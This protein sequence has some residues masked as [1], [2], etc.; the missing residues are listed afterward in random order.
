MAKKVMSSGRSTLSLKFF[1]KDHKPELPF[2]TVV[3]ENGTWQKV[4]SKFLQQ[5]LEFVLLE[6]SL[7]LKNTNELIGILDVHHGKQCSVF[8]MDIKDLYYSLESN[9]LMKRVKQALELNLVKFQSGSGIS[10]DSFLTVLDFYLRSTIVEYGGKMY[11]QKEGVCIGS[12]VAPIL[13]EIYLNSLDSAVVNGLKGIQSE[14]YVVK[15]YVDDIVVCSFRN[16][17]APQ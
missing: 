15:R 8:S 17:V 1:L 7:S 9:R 11:V 6:N 10:V 2:R 3:N 5:G 13:A 12:S 16:G 14:S 4:V